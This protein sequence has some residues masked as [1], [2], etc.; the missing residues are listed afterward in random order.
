MKMNPKTQAKALAFGGFIS[1]IALAFGRIDFNIIGFIY[2][3]LTCFLGFHNW[4][5]IDKKDALVLEGER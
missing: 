5:Q 4:I 2:S 3:A 1:F